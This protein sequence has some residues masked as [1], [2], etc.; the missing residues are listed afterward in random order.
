LGRRQAFLIFLCAALVGYL[1]YLFSSSWPFFFLGLAFA[2]A[3]Q[4]M[5]SP[6]IFAT[7]GDALPA[8]QREMGFTVQ[9]L[10]KRIPMVISPLLGTVLIGAMGLRMGIRTGLTITILCVAATIPVLRTIR[11]PLF[12]RDSRGLWQVWGSFHATLKRLLLSDIAIRT[13]EG[14]A[15][16]FVILYVT[17]I[18]GVTIPQY[19]I[20]VAVQLAT[21]I[22]VYI[23]SAKMAEDRRIQKTTSLLRQALVSLIAE[24]P[25]DS[26]V[27]KE[28]LDRANVGRSTFYTHFRDQDDC[29]SAASSKCCGQFHRRRRHPRKGTAALSGSVF[30]YSSTT[31]SM[32]TQSAR[33]IPPGLVSAYVASTF[34]LVLNWWLDRR[35]PVPPKEINQVFHTL[36]LPTLDAVCA[37]PTEKRQ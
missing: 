6:A 18:T 36:A 35:M 28:I 11:L 17:N 4:S 3:W 5:A 13:C 33:Q 20:L 25:Y 31:I 37:E 32:P 1:I 30:R 22:L 26:I 10:L 15:D 9:S 24:K 23:P 16:I 29:L 21:A 19:G 34:V 2:M 7:I 8:A 27:V 12:P 14:M